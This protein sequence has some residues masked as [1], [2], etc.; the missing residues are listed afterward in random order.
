MTSAVRGPGAARRVQGQLRPA[1]P[2]QRTRRARA[3]LRAGRTMGQVGSRFQGPRHM[4]GRR[5]RV[6]PSF[7]PVLPCAVGLTY[8]V[9]QLPAGTEVYSSGIRAR[10]TGAR[11]RWPSHDPVREHSPFLQVKKQAQSEQAL[12]V[13]GV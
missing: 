3:G 12:N 5:P 2:R 10:A 1:R 8:R 7:L 13:P 9:A 11:R 4:S 6:P